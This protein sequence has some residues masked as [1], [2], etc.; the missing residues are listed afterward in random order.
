[1]NLIRSWKKVFENDLEY[2]V[3]ELTGLMEPPAVL[4]L[5]GPLGSGK[6][7][8][9][10]HFIKKLMPSFGAT[11]PTYSTINEIGHILHGDF[12]RIKKMEEIQHLEL[13]LYGEDKA[14]CL[15]EWGKPWLSAIQREL[16]HD[17]KYYEL[18]IDINP[19]AIAFDNVSSRNYL[20]RKLD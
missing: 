20:L 2:I 17:F 19:K 12:Y 6:T 16:D 3:S 8:F 11:S 15:F 9:V 13:P 5:T 18:E 4:L 14:F 7:I 10:Q 1:M